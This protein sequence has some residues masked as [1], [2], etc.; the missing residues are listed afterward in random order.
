MG[1]VYRSHA[2][3]EMLHILEHFEVGKHQHGCAAHH[4]LVARVMAAAHAD[5]N[6]Y[7]GAPAFVDVPVHTLVI[8]TA[9]RDLGQQDMPQLR[10]HW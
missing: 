3:I 1:L 2:L 6:R 10:P 4:D 7:P 5:R 8:Q 9:R